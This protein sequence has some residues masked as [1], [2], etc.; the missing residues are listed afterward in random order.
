M[1]WPWQNRKQVVAERKESEARADT[2]HRELVRPLRLMRRQNHL[3]DAIV[4]DIR[5]R[6]KET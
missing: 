5:R 2:V 6:L 1:K 3:T 4:E